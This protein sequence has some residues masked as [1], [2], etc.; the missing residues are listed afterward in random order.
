MNSAY[1]YKEQLNPELDP[2]RFK[3]QDGR[4]KTGPKNLYTNSLN[5]VS[6]NYFKPYKHLPEPYERAH[7]LELEHH[8]KQKSKERE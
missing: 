3:M 1:T 2:K 8:Q 5:K 7:L 6:D 4:V